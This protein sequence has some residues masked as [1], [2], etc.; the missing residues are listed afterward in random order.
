MDCNNVSKRLQKELMEMM[1]SPSPGVAAFPGSDGNL[2]NWTATIEGPD[3][4]PYE[5]MT[6]KLSLKFP[7]NYPYSPPEVLFTT[8]MYHPN[9]DMA[10]RICLDILKDKWA[11]VLNVQS[12]LVSLQSLLGEPNKWETNSWFDIRFLKLALTNLSRILA[13][14][15]VNRPWMG[16][17]RCCGTQIKQNTNASS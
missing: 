15:P 2:M 1:M 9:V 3:G 12:V 13:Y 4:T 16:K 14:V 10:G 7:S 17:P 6:F 5:C 8:P 11:P